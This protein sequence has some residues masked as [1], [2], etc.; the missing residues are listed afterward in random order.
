MTSK[1][2]LD[3]LNQ[4]MYEE[5]NS[6]YIYA[7]MASDFEARGYLG[8]AGWMKKQAEEEMSHAW[9]IY[10][11]INS[12]GGKAVFQAIPQ[13]KADY[14]SVVET[15][16]ASLAHEQHITACIDKLV[17]LARD[18]KDLATE[19]FLGW[20]VSEQVEEEASV[21]EVLDKLKVLDGSP[22]T[23]YLLD[24]ELGARA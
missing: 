12:R 9:K 20:F 17:F 18:E 24:K 23:L 14:A 13:P 16:K 2:M 19:Q 22:S 15:F 11:Y 4:Q 3:K 1:N 6:F 8:F 21:Q 5:L 7:S 10:G